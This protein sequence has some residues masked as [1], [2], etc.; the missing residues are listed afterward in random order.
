M[1]SRSFD[2]V[3]F[4]V[5]EADF[6]LRKLRRVRGDFFPAQCYFSAFAAGT[7]SVTYSLQAVL[8]DDLGFDAWYA[9]HQ[10]LLKDDEIAKFFHLVRRIGHHVGECPVRSG[11]SGPNRKWLYYFVESDDFPVVPKTDVES[12]CRHYLT[13]LVDI[14]LDCYHAF[15]EVIDPE[16][17][18]TKAAFARHGK[19]LEDAYKEL[20]GVYCGLSDNPPTSMAYRL[21]AEDYRW[22]MLRD[23]MP[24]CRIDHLFR[25]YL[26]RERPRPERVAAPRP[27]AVVLP[28]GWTRKDGW[29][30]PPGY[31][32]IEAY[33]EA[34]KSGK[35]PRNW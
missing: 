14:V 32:E 20:Y 24:G 9:P 31:D 1:G 5:A 3:D 28:D 17:Y 29:L 10:K 2:L 8:S 15:G 12:A 26:K 35:A 34:L 13:L 33:L 11:S 30:L 22:Q 19:T 18:Y 27:E 4:K 16:Q 25:R 7:R 21:A 6:F 23:S